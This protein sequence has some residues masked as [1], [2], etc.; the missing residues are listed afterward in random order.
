MHNECALQV[1]GLRSLKKSQKVIGSDVAG[2]LTDLPLGK[3][4][5]DQ[6]GIAGV[7]PGAGNS[8]TVRSDLPLFKIDDRGAELAG[9]GLHGTDRDGVRSGVRRSRELGSSDSS[10]ER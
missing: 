10:A 5:A 3:V 9:R 8:G 7:K 2:P 1:K 4:G 6:E